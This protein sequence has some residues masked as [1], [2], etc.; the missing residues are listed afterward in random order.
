MKLILTIE[1]EQ[2]EIPNQ[3]KIKTVK[4]SHAKF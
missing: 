2:E 4:R 3:Q 1:L